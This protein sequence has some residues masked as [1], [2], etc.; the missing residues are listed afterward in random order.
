MPSKPLRPP[1][2]DT[3]LGGLPL[4]G[5]VRFSA[6]G[7]P[8]GAAA[9]CKPQIVLAAPDSPPSQASSRHPRVG[10]PPLGSPG[11]LLPAAACSVRGDS[12]IRGSPL[13]SPING[14]SVPEQKGHVAASRAV[15]TV[16]TSPSASPPPSAA[17]IQAGKA[18]LGVSAWAASAKMPVDVEVVGGTRES[19]GPTI[20]DRPPQSTL[21]RRILPAAEEGSAVSAFLEKIASDGTVAELVKTTVLFKCPVCGVV[22]PTR[23]EAA[24][25]CLDLQQT[26]TQQEASSEAPSDG[27]A[28]GP[29]QPLSGEA[30]AYDSRG[31]ATIVR[32]QDPETGRKRTIVRNEDGSHDVF[33]ESTVASLMDEGEKKAV[34]W[35]QGLSNHQLFGLNHEIGQRLVESSKMYQH[36]KAQYDRLKVDQ[37]YEYFGLTAEASDKDLDNA[38]RKLARQMHPDKQHHK[39]VPLEEAKEQFQQ[40]KKR[41]ESLKKARAEAAGETPEADPDDAGEDDEGEKPDESPKEDTSIK[42]DPT[43]R[44]SLTENAQK[45]L[46][47][48]KQLRASC[49]DI[50]FNLNLLKPSS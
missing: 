35:L 26:Q 48:L 43:N 23:E 42:Y 38:Y 33:G 36:H 16:A 11:G 32:Q 44:D 47:Q 45:M 7:P 22:C 24:T 41:Y 19:V 9:P 6:S 20:S 49:E 28:K 5:S 34:E 3:S 10:V 4:A 46:K 21:G 31:Q 8:Q 27:A 30:I 25:H 15:M 2:I 37:D 17:V 13:P 40:M 14:V 39:G 50:A 18:G 1:G 29:L 12:S